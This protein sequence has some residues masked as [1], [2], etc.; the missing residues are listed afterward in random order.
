VSTPVYEKY[1]ESGVPWLGKVPEHW[2]VAPLK[3]FA[4]FYGGG[5]PSKENLAFWNGDIPWVSPKDMKS[6][7]ITDSE[8]HI[9]PAALESSATNLIDAGA[10][11]VVVRSGILKHTI[12][13]AINK[14]PVTLNQDM[15]AII[16][17]EK[18]TAEY[19]TYFIRGLQIALLFEWC[20]VGVTVE[21]IEH[22]YLANSPF[23]IPPLAEQRAIASYLDR[24]TAR[25]DTLISRQERL[26]ELSLEKRR[27]L[28]GHA[29]TRGLDETAPRKASGIEW[30]GDVPAHW[31]VKRLKYLVS[32]PLQYGAS[33]AS[34]QLEEGDPRFIRITDIRENG[35]LRDD[36]FCSLPVEIAK[37][38]MLEDGDLL[39][40]RSGATVGKSFMYRNEFGPACFAG[41]LIR[42]NINKK[43]ANPVF[44]SYFTNSSFYWE[45]LASSSIQSTIQNV[46]AEKYNSL[47]IPLPPLSEQRAIAKYLDAETAKIDTLIAKARRAI[48]LMRE[49][50]SALIASA[51]T[52]QMDVRAA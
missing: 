22:E 36:S 21:S 12:P 9:T 42:A 33:E 3:Y 35:T 20:K 49:H 15:K 11:L 44:I 41:Y 34:G 31:G 29:V 27:A 14:V 28:I 43:K 47:S 18:V 48:E 39:F 51:V 17:N 38:F 10:V 23:I 1:K 2:E 37:S 45:W 24:E 13:V 40:A 7:F 46:N 8:D 4:N 19:L 52:G 16:L 26:V 25:L 6:D 5:T 32:T 50:R 30:L